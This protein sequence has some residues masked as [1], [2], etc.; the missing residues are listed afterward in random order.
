M[1]PL[2]A[3][4]TALLALGT[5]APAQGTPALLRDVETTSPGNPGAFFDDHP[6]VAW[7]PYLYFAADAEG[8]GKELWRSN[9][10]VANASL[11]VDLRLD[12]GSEPEPIGVLGGWLLFVAD[13]GV[14][15]RELWRTDGTPAGTSLLR[16][17]APG[18]ESASPSHFV[19][20]GSFWYYFLVGGALWKTDGQP[21]NTILV[22]QTTFDGNQAQGPTLLPTLR[23]ERT[24]RH[25]LGA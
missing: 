2:V 6:A 16:D 11:V 13:D 17:I 14:S 10:A 21:G 23:K 8:F 9:G 19:R 12:G 7:G 25:A 20:Y 15:G 3:T 24:M 5:P 22:G 4:A 18:A 1:K